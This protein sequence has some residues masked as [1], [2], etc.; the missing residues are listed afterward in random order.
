MEFQEKMKMKVMNQCLPPPNVKVMSC[1]FDRIFSAFRY[2]AGNS[3]HQMDLFL[4]LLEMDLTYRPE[5]RAQPLPDDPW[6]YSCIGFQNHVPD[7]PQAQ[8]DAYAPLNHFLQAYNLHISYQENLDFP[9]LVLELIKSFQENK[10]TILLIDQFYNRHSS[11]YHKMQN[12]NHAL[13]IKGMDTQQQQ[14]TICDKK[15]ISYSFEE[16]KDMMTGGIIQLSCLDDKGF[17]QATP[18]YPV[19]YQ[20]SKQKLNLL[21]TIAPFFQEIEQTMRQESKIAFYAKAYY[22]STLYQLIPFVTA[23]DILFQ[24]LKIPEKFQN[25]ATASRAK[26]EEFSY[27]LAKISILKRLSYDQLTHRTSEL[28]AMEQQFC[29]LPDKIPPVV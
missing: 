22:M 11:Y 27:W 25:A 29:Q 12:A 5:I 28:F 24:N 19:I 20:N 16:V 21:E 18:N 2:F 13:L 26:W 4:Y 8:T 3:P 17:F 15:D 1:I 14:I 6:F 9:A 10:V 7:N 23:R